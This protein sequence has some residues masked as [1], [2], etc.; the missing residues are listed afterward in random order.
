M[1]LFELTH[2]ITGCNIGGGKTDIAVAGRGRVWSLAEASDLIMAGQA[3]FFR[4]DGLLVTDLAM[5]PE[6]TSSP[7][8]G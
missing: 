1:Q 2:R 3:K 5:L 4:A 6:Q 8:V 7:A